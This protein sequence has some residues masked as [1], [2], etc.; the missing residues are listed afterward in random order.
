MLF[1]DTSIRELNRESETSSATGKAHFV[2]R[3]ASSLEFLV[4]Q[5]AAL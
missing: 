1:S 3:R 5:D 2:A 4:T